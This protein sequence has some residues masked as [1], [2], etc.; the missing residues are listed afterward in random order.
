MSLFIIQ[1]TKLTS[2]ENASSSHR[3]DFLLG[4]SREEASLDNDWLLGQLALAQHLSKA[5]SGDINDWC[6][7]ASLLVLEPGLLRHE[8]PQL[9]KVDGG[10]VEVGVVRM[11]VEISHPHFTEVSRVVLVEIP[12]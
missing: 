2:S 12:M 1:P 10:L 8:A 7:A 3:L 11:H 6:L 9:V 5:R 4:L